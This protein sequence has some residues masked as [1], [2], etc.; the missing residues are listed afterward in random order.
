MKGLDVL[1]EMS[2]LVMIYFAYI[3]QL[4]VIFLILS[5]NRS[6]KIHTLNFLQPPL[7]LDSLVSLIPQ[8]FTLSKIFLLIELKY[9][10]SFS[11]Y[12]HI[13]AYFLNNRFKMMMTLIVFLLG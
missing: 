11:N 13:F 8:F 6:L 12:F 4:V 5:L 3:C 7:Q 9:S 1:F 10:Y 2:E